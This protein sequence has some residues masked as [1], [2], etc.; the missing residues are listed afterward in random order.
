MA[1]ANLTAAR[2]RELLHYD[3]E[4]GVFKRSVRTSRSVHVGDIAGCKH[5]SG[6]IYIRV[7]SRKY[8]AHRLAWLYVCGAWPAGDIDHIDG[9][10]MNNRIANL[11]D[12]SKATNLQN[13]RLA[14]RNNASGF[15]GVSRKGLR[16]RARIWVNGELRIIGAFDDPAEAHAAYVEAKRK[17]HPGCTI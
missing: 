12:V 10:S 17:L 7:D 14:S 4:T 16:W 11:R 13:Q 9:N 1:K 6:Y 8:A 15:L 2:L 3:A 5:H